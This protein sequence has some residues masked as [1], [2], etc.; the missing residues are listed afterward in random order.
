VVPVAQ[1][2]QRFVCER[3][4]INFAWG[5]QHTGVY[6]DGAGRIYRFSAPKPVDGDTADRT[7]AAME[8]KYGTSTVVG[9]VDRKTLLSMYKLIPAA[10]GGRQ[11]PNV[12]VAYDAGSFV[13]ACF[14]FDPAT[15]RY[16]EVELEVKGDF[17][18]HNLAAEARVLAAWLLSIEQGTRKR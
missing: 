5:F 3:R 15:K 14:V 13:S 12:H 17:E 18:R 6:I 8:A 11:S 9:S 7:E 1:V 10:A 4:Y 16:R 2:P